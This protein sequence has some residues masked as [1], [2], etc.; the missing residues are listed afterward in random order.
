VPDLT[1]L[2]G[3]RGRPLY[4]FA[5]I[6][7]AGSRVHDAFPSWAAR[8]GLDA[9][10]RGLD[11][12]ADTPASTWERLVTIMRD[13]PDVHGAVITSHKLRLH[14]HAGHLVDEA[15][16]MVGVTREINALD[17]RGGRVRAFARDVQALEV[18]LDGDRPIVCL[19]SGGAA[20]AL[21][22]ANAGR[23]PLTVVGL[24][25][26]SLDH[27][28]AVPGHAA[29]ELAVAAGPDACAAVV[30]GGDPY[31]LIINATGLG[32]SGPGSPL[33]GPAAFPAASAAWDFNY[34]GPLT[35]LAQARAA[36]VPARDGWEYFLAGWACAL[37]AVTG[38]DAAATHGVIRA[39]T[40]R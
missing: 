11:L 23:R 20:V 29:A 32:K 10:L 35:F 5:G 26:A 21:L 4:L 6:D 24:D 1:W 16:P 36:G 18:L 12:P 39:A 37:A 31:S 8:L 27:L 17:T 22:R 33:P 3:Y 38:R 14:R 15:E 25:D 2:A 40:L 19:G 9:V 28:R 30:A 13:N 34:R 7:T